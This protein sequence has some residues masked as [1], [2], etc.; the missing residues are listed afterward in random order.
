MYVVEVS[1]QKVRRVVMGRGKKRGREERMAEV[2]NPT[3][4]SKE[5]LR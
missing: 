1:D 4:S 5:L 3:I 2:I